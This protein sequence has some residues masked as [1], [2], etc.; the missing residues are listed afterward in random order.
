MYPALLCFLFALLNICGNSALS[1][2][3][4]Y[5]LAIEYFN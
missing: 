2:D 4:Q 1:D 5:F 3:G